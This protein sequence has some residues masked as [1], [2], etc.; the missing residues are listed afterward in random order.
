MVNVAD[1]AFSE[2]M[3]QESLKTGVLLINLGTPDAPTPAAVGRYLREFLMDGYVIDIPKPLRWMLVNVV[4]VPRRRYASA[5][6]YQ[7]ICDENGSPLLYHTRAL[8]EG[9]AQNLQERGSD[10]IVDFGMRY[11]QPSIKDALQRLN[12]AGAQRILVL[13]LYPQYAESSFETAISETRRCAQTQGCL[14]KIEFLPPFY[15]HA[16]YLD[17][18][19]QRVAE[20]LAQDVPEHL[21]FS[22]HSLPE[23]HIQRLDKSGAHCLKKDDCCATIGPHNSLCYRAH[24]LHTAHAIAQKLGWPKDK[25]SISFQS[26]LG[27][28]AW[29]GPQTEDLLRD[30]A[31]R[32]VRKVAVFCPS[33]VADCLE[34][35][36][37][38]GLRARDVFQTAGGREIKLI[39]ALNTHPAWVNFVSDWL[40]QTAAAPK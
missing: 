22:F 19:A 7:N 16:G 3:N 24:S 9:V 15:D 33:F 40:M 1:F 21:V 8:T 12:A 34:T 14:D 36:E 6:L 23:R 28:A 38:I 32:G 31:Q 4:I 35:L 2:K 18:C 17:A 29:L 26:R 10:L 5:K 37:E 11:G 30:L 27:R 13:P 20:T 25:Y 39:P